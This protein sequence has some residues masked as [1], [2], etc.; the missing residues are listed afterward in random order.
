MV[1]SIFITVIMLI[2]EE[3]TCLM[4]YYVGLF[5]AVCRQYFK[6]LEQK[7]SPQWGSLVPAT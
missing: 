7:F 4:F 3:V 6:L 2:K 1:S 5:V